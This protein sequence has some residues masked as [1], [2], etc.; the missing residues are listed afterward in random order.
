MKKLVD[1]ARTYT[2]CGT[3]EYMAPEMVNAQGHTSTVDIWALGVL[4]YEMLCGKTPFATAADLNEKDTAMAV[5]AKISRH[6]KDDLT[7][8]RDDLSAEVRDLIKQLLDP[9]VD[10]RLGCQ[11]IIDIKKG[12]SVIR[13]HPWFKSIDWITL[14]S[15]TEAVG[16][17]EALTKMLQEQHNNASEPPELEPYSGNDSDWFEDF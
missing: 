9:I 5:Y 4:I 15:K 14:A 12:G 11:G 1:D 10:D 13:A 3:N 2:M 6:H 8:F 7:F 17:H 16:Q